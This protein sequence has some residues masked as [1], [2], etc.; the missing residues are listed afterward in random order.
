MTSP[1]VEVVVLGCVTTLVNVGFIIPT[2][3]CDGVKVEDFCGVMVEPIHE[4]LAL[5][6]ATCIC[7]C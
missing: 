3:V 5:R 1:S 4:S 2:Y 6:R 7:A